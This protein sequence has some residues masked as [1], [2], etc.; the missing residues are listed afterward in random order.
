MIKVVSIK[1]AGRNISKLKQNAALYLG[2]DYE[3]YLSLKKHFCIEDMNNRFHEAISSSSSDFF[4]VFSSVS[5]L[6]NV[7]IWSS[8]LASRN[9]ASVPLTRFL[10]YID[11]ATKWVR[12]YGDKSLLII[13]DS[14]DFG[15]FLASALNKLQ[16]KSRFY[17]TLSD[18]LNSLSMRPKI[19]LRALLFIIKSLYYS[20][21]F[22][23][24]SLSKDL[25]DFIDE[26]YILRPWVT[27][28]SI[29]SK[30]KYVD[31]NFDNLATYLEN[32]GKKV[33]ILPC[34]FNFK[35]NK[36]HFIKRLNNLGMNLLIPWKYLGPR[37]YLKSLANGFKS[38]RAVFDVTYFK[39]VDVAPLLN[40]INRKMSLDY[41]LLEHNLAYELLCYLADNDRKIKKIIYPMENNS[42]EKWLILGVKKFMPKT[43]IAGFQHSVWYKEQLGMFVAA[44]EITHPIPDE[45]IY[46]GTKYY[47][48]F[49]K[50][51]FPVERLR[52]GASLR[53]SYIYDYSEVKEKDVKGDEKIIAVILNFEMNQT[54]EV[55]FKTHQA[56]E[57]ISNADDY[58]IVIKT[59]PLTNI[60][61]LERFLTEIS[62]LNYEISENKNVIELAR[63]ASLVIMPFG[64]VSNLEVIIQGVPLIR[65]SL[66]YEFNFDPLWTDY[67][68]WGNANNADV[69]AEQMKKG[70]MLSVDEK[71]MLCEYGIKIRNNYFGPIS[72]DSLSVFI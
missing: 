21:H 40:L 70:I 64:S 59:H 19:V 18:K 56:L 48:V 72:K 17:S 10:A 41:D 67:P 60:S 62:F 39:D 55:L 25:P 54:K 51:G 24:S 42:I 3:A 49:Q 6:D 11:I 27:P 52:P 44:E 22:K 20:F 32:N 46:T 35:T 45:I 47:D 65:I 63:S 12:G 30:G 9:S 37:S 57:M 69:L 5:N 31:R 4:K 13:V 29:N 66:D 34:F 68:L 38:Y 15:A 33:W 61:E 71:Q 43:Q 58:T 53:F 16:L 8:H 23:S 26:N 36:L 14:N 1:Y 7:Y 50:C 2:R 28:D